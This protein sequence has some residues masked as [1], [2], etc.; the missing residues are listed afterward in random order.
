MDKKLLMKNCCFILCLAILLSVLFLGVVNPLTKS[1]MVDAEATKNIDEQVDSEI[2]SSQ[3]GLIEEAGYTYTPPK[4]DRFIVKSA[5]G[6][7][8]ISEDLLYCTFNHSLN[9]DYGFTLKVSTVSSAS[10]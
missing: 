4:T 9:Q 1:K 5:E 8:N 10:A 7:L 3:S 6:V 2:L